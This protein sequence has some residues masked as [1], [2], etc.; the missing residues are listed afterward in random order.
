[1]FP[2]VRK[3][4]L[5]VNF[6][7]KFNESE[8]KPKSKLTKPEVSYAQAASNQFHLNSPP[9]NDVT[10]Q[11]NKMLEIKLMMRELMGKIVSMLNILTTLV[12]K[13]T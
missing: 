9:T 5:P 12:A 1:M 2:T 11:N 8:S 10:L 7:L 6:Q 3:K 13:M 4:E